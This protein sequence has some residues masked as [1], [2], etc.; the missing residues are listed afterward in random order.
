MSSRTTIKTWL[1]VASIGA[2]EA[3]KDQG[4]A[5][6]NG[7]IKALHHHAKTKIVS[8]YNRSVA[9]RSSRSLFVGSELAAGK[10]RSKKTKEECMKKVMDMNCFGPSTVR[11]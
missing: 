1:V 10:Y 6:W 3:L 2:V 8:S 9:D 4:V 11:F 7:P 5:R